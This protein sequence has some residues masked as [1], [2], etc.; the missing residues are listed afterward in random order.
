MSVCVFLCL[1][2]CCL[3]C[4]HDVDQFNYVSPAVY[5]ELMAML[6]SF[7]KMETTWE[8]TEIES[9]SIGILLGFISPLKPKLFF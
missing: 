8:T 9:G 4:S 3:E 2:V 5:K 6:M 1:C 7:E